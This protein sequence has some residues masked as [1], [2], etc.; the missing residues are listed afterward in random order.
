MIVGCGSATDGWIES[1]RHV[2]MCETCGYA[3]GGSDGR[4]VSVLVGAK[5]MCVAAF[6]IRF[7]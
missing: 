5:E 2:D 1:Q 3:E 4:R 6:S 7:S